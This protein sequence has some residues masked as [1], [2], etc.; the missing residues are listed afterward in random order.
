MAEIELLTSGFGLIEGP[1][2]DAEDTQ[3]L[4]GGTAGHWA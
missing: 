2:V 1:R 4:T 3:G